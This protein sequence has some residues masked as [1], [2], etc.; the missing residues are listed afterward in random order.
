MLMAVKI[1]FCYAHEDASLL[2]K[3][4]AHL[5]P[6]E[7]LGLI[8]MWY[9][10]EISVGTEWE[11]EI[12]ERLNSAQIILLLVSSAFMNSDYAYGIELEHAI[13]RHNLGEARII[14]II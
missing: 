6:L 4:K 8:E 3:L 13:K 7:R 5:R 11:T 14:P 10:R 9:D 12:K 2:K 1:F